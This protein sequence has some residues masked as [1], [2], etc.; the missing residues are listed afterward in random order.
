MAASPYTASSI[1]RDVAK[2]NAIS[3]PAVGA[4]G[5]NLVLV[6][7][8][9]L[10]AVGVPDINVGASASLSGTVLNGS[11]PVPYCAVKLYRRQLGVLIAQT[12]TNTSG[13]F[14]FGDLPTSNPLD[15]FAVAFDPPGGS[16]ENALIFDYLS[17]A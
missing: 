9:P 8:M 11:T 17:P 14:S 5:V 16:V 15:Y 10:N 13:A 3:A 2:T 6:R 4:R 1:K 12:L 7:K